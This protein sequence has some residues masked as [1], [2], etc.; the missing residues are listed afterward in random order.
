MRERLDR[1]EWCAKFQQEPFVREGLLFPIEQLRFFN[2]I[3]PD[4]PKKV[5]AAL[6]PAFGKGDFLSMPVCFDYP[7]FGYYYRFI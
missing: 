1:A 7:F 6:D 2:G 4:A 5:Y 3:V